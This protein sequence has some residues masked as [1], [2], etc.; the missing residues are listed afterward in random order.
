MAYPQLLNYNVYATLSS[1][2]LQKTFLKLIYIY[3]YNWLVYIEKICVDR[4]LIFHVCLLRMSG[5]KYCLRP[6]MY[7]T[8]RRLDKASVGPV[9]PVTGREKSGFCI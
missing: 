8:P 4:S 7:T 6:K 2:P 9:P 1:Y 5:L 3:I